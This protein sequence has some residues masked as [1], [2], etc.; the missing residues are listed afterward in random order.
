[1]DGTDSK[2][3][4]AS[5]RIVTRFVKTAY[6]FNFRKAKLDGITKKKNLICMLFT[7][8]K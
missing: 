1:M 7:F 6:G 3:Y 2:P 8:T 4:G 5:P